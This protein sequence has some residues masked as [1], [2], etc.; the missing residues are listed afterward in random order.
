MEGIALVKL[1]KD[2]IVRHP[3]V[4]KIVR[5]YEEGSP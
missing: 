1:G 2:D 3:L 4:G 5:A